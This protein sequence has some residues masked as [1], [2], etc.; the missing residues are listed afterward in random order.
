[1][2]GADFS[3]ATDAEVTVAGRNCRIRNGPSWGLS[4]ITPMQNIQ[5]L[6]S[7]TFVPICPISHD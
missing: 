5:L 3:L 6:S 7:E 2:R 1:M 4:A